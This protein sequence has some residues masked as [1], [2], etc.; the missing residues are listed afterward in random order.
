[1]NEGTSNPFDPRVVLGL[2]LFG[3]VTF[4]ALLWMIGS[5]M[6]AGS[7]NDGGNH[8][9]GKGLSGFAAV[10]DLLE[11]RGN[12]IRKITSKGAHNDAGLLIL[13]PPHFA[14][15]EEIG[16]AI[17]AHRYSGPTML[18]L[19]KWAAFKVPP[20]MQPETAREGWVLLG[21]AMLPKWADDVPGIGKLGLRTGEGGSWNGLDRSGILPNSKQVQSLTSGSIVPLVRDARGQTLAGYLGDN[22][23]Y[24]E[25]DE[26]AGVGSGESEDKDIY[27]LLIV[28]EPDLLNNYGFANRDRAMLALDLIGAVSEGKSDPI[29]FDL[30][31]NGHA[32]SANLLTLAFTPPFLAAT[33]CLLLAA[34]ALGWRAFLRFGPAITAGRSIAYGKRALVA[35]AAGLIRRTRRRHLVT[36]PYAEQVRERLARALALPRLAD[37]QATEAAIDRALAGRSGSP[38]P[39]STLARRL[40][41]ASGTSDILDAAHD[42]HALERTLKR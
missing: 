31:L 8:A 9:G 34:L 33:L 11:K 6:N 17:T 2:I 37:A 30:T 40:C 23:Y 38:T 39:F 5:G 13:T 42:L 28:A 18:V 22:G 7:F 1:M 29:L 27:P 36:S 12:P 25:L 3:A 16:E 15:A 19:P 20:A 24:P 4:V 32:R 14:D 26:L 10:S 41:N 35:N 21:E